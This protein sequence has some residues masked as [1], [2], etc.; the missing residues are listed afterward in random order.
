MTSACQTF[1]P[2]PCRSIPFKSASIVCKLTASYV[3]KHSWLL[4]QLPFHATSMAQN[5]IRKTTIVSEFTVRW[6]QQLHSQL[7]AISGTTSNS[8]GVGVWNPEFQSLSRQNLAL[9]VSKFRKKSSP[10]YMYKVKLPLDIKL[11]QQ[12]LQ[13]E[14]TVPCL[15]ALFY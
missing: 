8:N 11:T 4:D 6:Q 5:N 9:F 2:W 3:C 7:S 14:K 1:T 12:S 10:V 15:Q 13:T